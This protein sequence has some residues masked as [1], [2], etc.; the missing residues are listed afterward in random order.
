MKKIIAFVDSDGIV[1]ATCAE[2]V[3]GFVPL[4]APDDFDLDAGT[5]RAV[6][7]IAVLDPPKV[8]E[9]TARLDE[10]EAALVELASLIA[11]GA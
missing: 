11:G 10:Q 5:W 6:A 7:G 8:D 3:S 1:T 9:I 4:Q 2:D